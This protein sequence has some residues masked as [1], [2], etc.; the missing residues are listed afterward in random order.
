[1]EESELNYEQLRLKRLEE[2]KK[3]MEELNLNKLAQALR[4]SS[5]LKP[6]PMK[7]GKPRALRQPVDSSAVRRSSRMALKPAPNYT[8]KQVNRNVSALFSSFEED[9]GTSTE[10][11]TYAYQNLLSLGQWVLNPDL[12]C[13][14]CLFVKL[15][16]ELLHRPRRTY[17]R[18]DLLNRKYASDEERAYAIDRVKK[19]QSNLEP[20]FPSFVKPM[21]Q[22]HVTG[23]FWLGLPL[24]F[25]KAH[26]PK[27]DEMVTLVDEE[28]EEFPTKYLAEKN[29][30]S[31]GWRGFSINHGLVDGDALLFQLVAPT[32]FKVYI[33]RVYNDDDFCANGGDKENE[34]ENGTETKELKGTAKRKRRGRGR[35]M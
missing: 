14:G 10:V 29:G 26:L 5:S 30:L 18:R 8:E 9:F 28:G 17:R 33:I 23:G 21:L 25:C 3:R 35:R 19:L 24:R 16:L 32:K 1:M 4:G 7:R 13:I 34:S 11:S 12:S 15:G 31:G 22:S 20:E 27:C 6:S 2:N